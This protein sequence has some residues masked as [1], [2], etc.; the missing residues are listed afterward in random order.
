MK[1]FA[2]IL[3]FASTLQSFAQD[4]TLFPAQVDMFYLPDNETTLFRC[5]QDSSITDATGTHYYLNIVSP[6]GT[7]QNCYDSMIAAFEYLTTSE[8]TILFPY[9]SDDD[10]I[11]QYNDEFGT[12]PAVFKPLAPVG[13]SWTV[14]NNA[15]FADDDNIQ[16]TCDSIVMGNVFGVPDSLKYFSVQTAVPYA[17]DYTID[18]VTFILSKNHGFVR[19][20]PLYLLLSPTSCTY[21]YK[22]YNLIGWDSDFSTGGYPGPRWEDWI[23]LSPGDFLK[24]RT[25]LN[26]EYGTDISYYT[27]LI[28]SVEHYEDSIVVYV[29]NNNGESGNYTYYKDVIYNFISS[30]AVRPVR[31]PNSLLETALGDFIGLNTTYSYLLDTITFAGN[32]TFYQH[33]ELNGYLDESDCTIEPNFEYDFTISCNSYIGTTYKSDGAPNYFWY[34]SLIG[35]VISGQ[36]YGN[37]WPLTIEEAMNSNAQ[38]F[39]YPN[40]AY[41]ILSVPSLYGTVK[42]ISIY[43]VTG[44]LVKF[45]VESNGSIDIPELAPGTYIIKAKSNLGQHAGK[46]IK[47]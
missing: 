6:E 47:Q 45:I 39:V 17:G 36:Q 30:P 3:F 26:S 12:L 37:Y 8:P 10:S 13:Y 33:V 20:L 28:E 2:F 21:C 31:M 23:K 18:K 42:N 38:I 7:T 16:I 24:Y 29:L 19:F 35:Y 41:D 5:K 4:W 40:P 9:T 43:D 1:Q 27:H 32:K 11:L 34:S 25:Y 44:R 46:F 15:A 22:C 14:Y